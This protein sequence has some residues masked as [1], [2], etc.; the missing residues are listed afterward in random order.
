[1][2]KNFF[3][4]MIK[5]KSDLRKE[6][7]DK[8]AVKTERAE[9]EQETVEEKVWSPVVLSKVTR[10]ADLTPLVAGRRPRYS[11]WL[12][13]FA[14]V[15]FLFFAV[16]FFLSEASISVNPKIEDVVF[17]QNISAT[18]DT[19]TGESV[20]FDLIVLS[21]EESKM[22]E[23]GAVQDVSVSAK[24][25]VVIYNNYSTATQ[26]LDINTRLEGSNG[27]LYKTEKQ[28]V[29]PGL[30]GTTPGSVEVGV[31]AAEAGEEYNSNPLD[32]QIF[33]FKGTPKYSK[34]YAR[35]KGNITGGFKGKTS[36]IP[37][38]KK[39][40]VVND[41]RALLEAKLLKKATDLIPEGFVLFKDA[42]FLNIDEE[43]F[44]SSLGGEQ[45]PVSIKGTFFGFLFEEKEL[46]KKI[47]KAAIADYDE[48]DIFISNIRDLTFTFLN[49]EGISGNDVENISFNLAGKPKVVWKF[50]D[51]KL[52][53]DIAGKSKQDFYQI[54][55]QYP[56][57]LSADVVL[58]PLW[59]RSFP[60]D[61]DDIK[62]IVNYPNE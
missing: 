55:S 1:M 11:I 36:A 17:N 56:N 44:D 4:D 30:K 12:V 20:S 6:I 58:R 46:A 38:A 62:I 23:G 40:I 24:G 29:V 13:A 28:I 60:D 15:V 22:I 7:S 39:E 18:K 43:S 53:S 37:S 19:S 54:L 31:Y 52:K 33:G 42:I 16:S 45:V 26:R 50:D 2:A 32:F 10:Q 9:P 25:A 51:N 41:M 3:Q 8:E 34:F 49:R 47:A 57:V 61:Q 14:S 59:K 27:K 21:G 5:M 35:S 48:S